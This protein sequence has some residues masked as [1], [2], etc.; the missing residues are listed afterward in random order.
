MEGEVQLPR[1]H[2]RADDRDFKQIVKVKNFT[3]EK[4]IWFWKLTLAPV[5]CSRGRLKRIQAP[6]STMSVSWTYRSSIRVRAVRSYWSWL[7][8]GLRVTRFSAWGSL[9]VS[10]VSHSFRGY[11]RTRSC[12]GKSTRRRH[13]PASRNR[14]CTITIGRARIKT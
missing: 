12:R 11:P 5:T 1:R 4:E 7:N 9:R 10:W 2:L 14:V 6:R 3:P 8:T 13:F